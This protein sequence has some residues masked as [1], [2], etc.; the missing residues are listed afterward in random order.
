MKSSQNSLDKGGKFILR[1]ENT[2]RQS[3]EASEDNEIFEE[4]QIVWAEMRSYGA[5]SD[6]E[7]GEVGSIEVGKL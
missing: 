1:G 3:I 2:K 4:L 5:E 7:A 6:D